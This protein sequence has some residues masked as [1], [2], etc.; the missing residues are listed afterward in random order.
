MFLGCPSVVHL[1]INTY[2]FLISGGILMKLDTIQ[3][4][5][6]LVGIVFPGPGSKVKVMQ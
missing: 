1:S 6:M 3:I 2:I 5:I 4:F